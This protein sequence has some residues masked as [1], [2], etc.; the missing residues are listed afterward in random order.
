MLDLMQTICPVYA[1]TMEMFLSNS[2]TLFYEH[3][4]WIPT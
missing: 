2:S 3:I 1:W 4:D